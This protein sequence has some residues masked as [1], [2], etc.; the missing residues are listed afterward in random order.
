MIVSKILTDN[1]VYYDLHCEEV[2]TSN[3]IND[4]NS[5]IY[6]DSFQIITFDRIAKDIE[7]KK[8]KVKNIILD[9]KNVITSVQ[10]NLTQKITTLKNN[11]YDIAL[12][13]ILES[14]VNQMSLNALVNDDNL[15]LNK[16]IKDDYTGEL[17]NRVYYKKFYLFER[18]NNFVDDNFNIQP[19]FKNYFKDTLIPYMEV[20]DKQHTS[21]FVYLKSFV[22]I[23]KVI[24]YEK[25]MMI[26]SIYLLAI[27]IQKEWKDELNN[28][29]VLVCQSLN[30]SFIVST[31]SILLKLDIL[32]LDKIGPI[33]KLYNRLNNNISN[34]KKYIVVSDL[35]CLGTEVKIVKNLIEFMGGKYLGNVAI[36][37]TQ[38]LRK[39]DILRK[40]ATLAVFSIDNTNNKEL[41]YYI[42]TELD[43]T[44]E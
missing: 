4:D 26:Y 42:T 20:H 39:A 17:S 28:N 32:I 12:I 8:D 13:N 22:N 34:Q 7:N 29:A 36:I 21:S 24:S 25:A 43:L 14:V 16:E 41:N 38:T 44:N 11:G 18:T 10:P 3:F 23:K 6:C 40:D 31:L 27:K 33:N 5:G 30:S 15:K 35:V 2:I 19:F 37:K 1:F 9:F